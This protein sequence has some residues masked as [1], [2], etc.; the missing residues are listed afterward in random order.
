MSSCSGPVHKVLK[1]ARIARQRANTARPAQQRTNLQ[2]AAVVVVVCR[3][4]AKI[5]GPMLSTIS[6]AKF[7]EVNDK[8]WQHAGIMHASLVWGGEAVRT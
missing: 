5:S 4:A 7:R 8:V 3:L 2:R 6:R 1:D